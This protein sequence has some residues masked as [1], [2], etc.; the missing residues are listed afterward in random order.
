MCNN[1]YKVFTLYEIHMNKDNLKNKINQASHQRKLI[2]RRSKRIT[3]YDSF[4]EDPDLKEFKDA[5]T[6]SMRGNKQILHKLVHLVMQYSRYG[7]DLYANEKTIA[8]KFGCSEK[9]LSR[10]IGQAADMGIIYAKQRGF[11][12][13]NE[14]F[15]NPA[16]NKPSVQHALTPFFSFL[17]VFA[18]Q[19]LL[20]SASHTNLDAQLVKFNTTD[21]TLIKKGYY[22]I[23]RQRSAG[24]QAHKNPERYINIC[25]SV[26]SCVKDRGE[27]ESFYWSRGEK[28]AREGLEYDVDPRDMCSNKGS[29]ECLFV[30]S[31][32]PT[33]A[34]SESFDNKNYVTEWERDMD[35]PVPYFTEDGVWEE[36]DFAYPEPS[37]TESDI[38]SEEV[39]SSDE[40]NEIEEAFELV[41]IQIDSFVP[42]VPVD[43]G[44]RLISSPTK[45][46]NAPAWRKVQSQ[47]DVETFTEFIN[48]VTKKKGNY[49]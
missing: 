9:A 44:E 5:L 20:S 15:I 45:P 37:E 27:T 13:P 33:R 22:F 48:R 8:K 10:V 4:T 18:L 19:L 38:S 29:I 40:D 28:I 43:T 21:V 7:V 17:K 32:A 1:P 11:N 34:T 12:K 3:V 26:E 30:Q 39:A 41:K 23:N 35:E 16:F 42:M 46:W 24:E 36:V 47:N 2:N 6:R 49:D 31:N 25:G 14:Y